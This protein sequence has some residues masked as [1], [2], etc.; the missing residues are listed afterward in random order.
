[1]PAA[2]AGV[3]PVALPPPV[4]DVHHGNLPEAYMQ[5]VVQPQR[6]PIRQGL[7]PR[8]AVYVM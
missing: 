1:M 8:Q 7:A 6:T 5:L 4:A 3:P 2:A